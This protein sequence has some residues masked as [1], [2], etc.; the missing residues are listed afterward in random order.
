MRTPDEVLRE[1]IEG[2]RRF[3]EGDTH[4]RDLSAERA[5]TEKGQSP[6]AIVMGCSDSRVP[7]ELLFD[8]GIGDLFVIRTAGHIL[9]EASV[10]SIEFAIEALGVPVVIVL[11]HTDCAAVKA[12]VSGTGGEHAAAWLADQVRSSL[13]E[14][15]SVDGHHTDAEAIHARCVARRVAELSG[16]AERI[17]AGTVAVRPAVYDVASGRVEFG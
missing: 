8:Q 1:L 11:G 14:E 17:S 3:L 4:E 16:V 5:R 2:N 9:G 6:K 15:P 12:G 10:H 13:A 7:A